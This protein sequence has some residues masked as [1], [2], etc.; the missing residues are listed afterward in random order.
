MWEAGSR[1]ECRRLACPIEIRNINGELV[2]KFD[3]SILNVGCNKINWSIKDLIPGV[4]FG[5]RI[6]YDDRVLNSALPHIASILN[7]DFVKAATVA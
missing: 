5:R 7:K 4:Y 6:L 3:K 2:K 1:L